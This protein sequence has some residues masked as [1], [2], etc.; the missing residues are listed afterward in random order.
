ML[1][2]DYKRLQLLTYLDQL[3]LGRPEL[4]EQA[5]LVLSGQMQRQIYLA[6]LLDSLRNQKVVE[7][8]K[9]ICIFVN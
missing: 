9:L 6:P 4:A 2:Q 3:C 8:V 7:S 1:L 5:F